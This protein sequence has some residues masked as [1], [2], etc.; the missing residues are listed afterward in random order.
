MFILSLD[1]RIGIHVAKGQKG[2]QKITGV[3]EV[4]THFKCSEASEVVGLH[5]SSC[6]NRLL[7]KSLFCRIS[8]DI[9][10]R[11]FDNR[12]SSRQRVSNS[13]KRTGF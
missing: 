10:D 1:R 11:H 6:F 8:T 3:D 2:T 9:Q 7:F 4:E 13:S 12:V 5:V